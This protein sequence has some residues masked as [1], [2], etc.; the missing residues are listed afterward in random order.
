VYA[1]LRETAS[2]LHNCLSEA[3]LSL[4]GQADSWQRTGK[5]KKR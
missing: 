2:Y 4:G 1:A 5:N 3:L